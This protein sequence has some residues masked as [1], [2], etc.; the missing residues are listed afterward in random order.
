MPAPSN[1]APAVALDPSAAPA[2]V[3]VAVAPGWAEFAAA[4]GEVAGGRPA[5]VLVVGVAVAGL[6]IGPV[7]AAV[8]VPL[9]ERFPAPGDILAG[10]RPRAG[11]VR[12]RRTWPMAIAAALSFALAGW[13]WGSH[14]G[15]VPLLF[16]SAVLVVMSAVDLEHRR[17]PDR[18]TVPSTFVALPLLMIVAG[19]NGTPER[20]GWAALGAL[21]FA[22]PL[23]VL[24]LAYPDGMGFGDVKL[25][26]LLGAY[27]GWS[28]SG[29][30]DVVSRVLA[31]L[32]VASLVGSVVGVA[33]LLRDRQQRHYPF[34]PWLALGALSVLWLSPP[35]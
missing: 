6:L 33:L 29:V 7:L 4:N 23:Y 17:I 15:L 26:P 19:V 16:L 32:F 14:G 11:Q 8:S 5:A 10:W 12:P 1:P 9:H 22:A 24:H 34:G 28:A 30:L 2:V 27:L 18:L 35:S 13:R 21:A 25:A 20:V 3:S 31:A